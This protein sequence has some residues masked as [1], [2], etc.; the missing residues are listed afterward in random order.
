PQVK[1]PILLL[2]GDQ[3]QVI[4]VKW[5]EQVK[6]LSPLL[7]YQ[8]IPNAGHCVYDEAAE[9]VINAVEDWLG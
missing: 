6:P 7:T 2:W 3:D 8:E 1:V 5:A 9:T 4:P